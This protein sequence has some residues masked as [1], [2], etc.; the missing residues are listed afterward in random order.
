MRK[1]PTVKEIK[2][3]FDLNG[4]FEVM[5]SPK[6]DHRQSV[7]NVE[8]EYYIKAT[9]VNIQEEK[10]T[11]DESEP[12]MYQV[13]LDFSKYLDYNH[14]TYLPEYYDKNHNATLKFDESYFYPKNHIFSMYF[15][16][17]DRPFEV[18]SNKQDEIKK[19]MIRAC[20][21]TRM[22]VEGP[23]CKVSVYKA[24]Y[25]LAEETVNEILKKRGI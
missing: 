12:K 17:D 4:Q 25:K 10:Y 21:Q 23:P 16:E 14:R 9:F 6:E 20:V 11:E 22:D 3:Y 1:Y 5:T 2:D 8:F 18:L 7:I 13:F 19:L 24:W 15:M